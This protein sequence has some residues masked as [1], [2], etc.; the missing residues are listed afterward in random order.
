MLLKRRVR[1]VR[2]CAFALQAAAEAEA[3]AGDGAPHVR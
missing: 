3:A 1:V 2:P